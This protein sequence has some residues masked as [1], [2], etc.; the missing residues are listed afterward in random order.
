MAKNQIASKNL[1]DINSVSFLFS[2]GNIIKVALSDFPKEIIAHLAQHG[3]SQK[4]GDSY[5]GVEG[6]VAQAQVNLQAVVESLKAG[7][8][9]SRVGGG[10]RMTL[11][12]LA[13]AEVTNRKVEEV[14]EKVESLSKEEKA[15]Y[16]QHPAIKAVLARMEVER[17]TAKA[18]KIAAAAETAGEVE[19]VTL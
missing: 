3:L 18:A 4:G 9:V 15:A 11:L 10:P 17:A 1:E 5:A 12:I 13:L 7:D 2:D 19:P 16:R 8:W 6:D 14:A